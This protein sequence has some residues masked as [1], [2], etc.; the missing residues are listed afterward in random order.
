[1]FNLI[2][3]LIQ[4]FGAPYVYFSSYDDYIEVY[5]NTTSPI[6]QCIMEHYRA[7]LTTDTSTYREI[8]PNIETNLSRKFYCFKVTLTI[9]SKDVNNKDT[10]QSSVTYSK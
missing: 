6:E 3:D 10:S 1:M 7:V 8:P 2:L 5:W 9:E 4:P